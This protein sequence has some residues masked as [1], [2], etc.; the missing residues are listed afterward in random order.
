M[1]LIAEKSILA[2]IENVYPGNG[3]IYEISLDVLKIII[4]HLIMDLT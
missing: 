1:Q 3:H 4:V 2:Q